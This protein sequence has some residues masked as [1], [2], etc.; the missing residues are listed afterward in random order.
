[1]SLVIRWKVYQISS[2]PLLWLLSVSF[3]MMNVVISGLCLILKET[4]DKS[5]ITG[6]EGAILTT[7]V[8]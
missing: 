2:F 5:K 4:I 3:F 8:K 1:M 7:A 6:Q